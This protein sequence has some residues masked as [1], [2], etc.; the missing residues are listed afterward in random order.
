MLTAIERK[1]KR[2][3]MCLNHS[4]LCFLESWQGVAYAMGYETIS[5]MLYIEYVE[6]MNTLKEMENVIGFSYATIAN[7]LRK[8][9]VALRHRGCRTKERRRKENMSPDLR[10]LMRLRHYMLVIKAT[11][12]N[13]I[14]TGRKIELAKRIAEY[15]SKQSKKDWDAISSKEVQTFNII[16]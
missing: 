10:L 3:K 6:E 11:N 5:D 12:Y 14:T 7:K 4:D 1:L 9:G 13:L 15:E 16:S 8:L 2:R